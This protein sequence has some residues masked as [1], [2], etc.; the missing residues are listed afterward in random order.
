MNQTSSDIQ[1]IGAF[2]QNKFNMAAAI[3]LTMLSLIGN[4]I[5]FC[6][7]I[8]PEFIKIPLFRYLIASTLVETLSVLFIWASGF[9]DVFE[10]NSNILNCKLYAYLSI[11]LLQIGPWI[12]VLSSLDRYLSVTYPTKYQFRYEFIYQAT[13]L[14]LIVVLMLSINT[15]ILI[16]E[17]I[18]E[19]SCGAIEKAGVHLTV[20]LSGS[21]HCI[22]PSILMLSLNCLTIYKLIVT[23][24]QMKKPSFIKEIQLAKVLFSLNFVFILLNL[25]YSIYMSALY[26]NGINSF[27]TFG[28]HIVVA[29]QKIDY[30]CTFF[31]Y[32]FANKLFRKHAILLCFKNRIQPIEIIPLWNIKIS[33]I[34]NAYKASNSS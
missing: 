5:V 18:E 30:S 13:F 17:R 26:F 7:L 22:L 15:P 14:L 19:N 34:H 3:L 31:V 27:H 6:V 16:Y 29:L 9:P 12:N 10:I 11:I 33:R 32:F 24:K 1:L 25:P 23:Q 20:L 8:K 2:E 21:M 4:S 28:F